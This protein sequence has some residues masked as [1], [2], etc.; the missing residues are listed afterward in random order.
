M[1][2][3]IT[4]WI[5]SFLQGRDT[6]LQF[7]GWKSGQIPT[8]AGLPQ[9]SPLSPLLYMYYNADLLDIAP[10]R[11]AVG[12]GFID[13]VVYGVKSNSDRSNVR[14]L[15]L[16]L[17]E[18]ERWRKAHG[19]Q[20]EVSKYVLVHFT[21]NNR[22]RT[23]ASITVGRSE[24]VPSDEAKYL[25]VV[26]DR[27]LRFGSHL[28]LLVKRGTK[29]ALAL[30][31][32]AKSSWGA[33]YRYVRQLFLAVIAPST[34]YGAVVW[35]RPMYDGSTASSAQIRRLTT[36]QRLAM[37]AILGCY[38]TTPT[39]AMEMES[40]LEPA[41]IRLQTK[42]LR[43]VARMQ[44]LSAAHP[45]QSH[46]ASALRTRTAD[47]THRSNFENVLQQFP[48]LTGWSETIEP[49]IRP[50]WWIPKVKIRIEETKEGAKDQH[51]EICD[52][53]NALTV[54]I[55]TDGSGI[56][57]KVGAA[58]YNSTTNATSHQH[59]GNNTQFNVY[60]AELTALHLASEQLQNLPSNSV[61]RMYTDSQAALRAIDHPRRQSG[62][63]IVKSLLDCID[64][65]T[66]GEP[67]LRIEMV[68]IPGHS[69]IEGNER[70]DAE[71]KRAALD[72]SL[73]KRFAYKALK[74][75]RVMHIKTTAKEQWC[76]GWNEDTKTASALRRIIG[77]WYVKNGPKLYNN[78]ADRGMAA[79]IVQL[80]TGHCGL[81]NYLYRFGIS[82]TPYCECGY[83]KET[84]EHFLL[85]C[86][87]YKEQ[88]R[89][90]RQEVGVG[91]MRV[92]KLLG[93]P[94]VIKKTLE[95]V[96]KTERFKV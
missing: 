8:P 50:P 27:G 29:A 84:V 87:R 86:R 31:S 3:G 22:V 12:I 81:N 69:G 16:I 53:P 9:G 2:E 11:Q 83:G 18:A 96:K 89:V 10:Q 42:V 66:D 48:C 5:S 71:A 17:E 43:S 46:L 95:Y 94:K 32:I 19:A 61:C 73:S 67:H 7:N 78:L 38:R 44:S 45:I 49:Y 79:T 92:D 40:G 60:A 47:V 68:W 1:P 82:D 74:S 23:D 34:D 88:R 15:R 75:A 59:L 33:P 28:Q 80:R 85:E 93:D 76:K 52:N 6:K 57:N 77:G 13:D 55:Y 24:I 20:F 4:R 72:Q 37:K 54:A 30:A 26:F 14:K 56:E 41:W 58:A 51:D 91:K 39:A 70:A 90:L 65:A 63:S 25:G 21:R 62:Q 64:N 35:H 36:I